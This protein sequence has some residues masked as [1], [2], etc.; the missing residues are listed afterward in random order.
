MYRLKI[1]LIGCNEEVMPP[2]AREILRRWAIIDVD[3]P[4]VTAIQKNVLAKEGETRLLII[5]IRSA[6]DLSDL[7]RLN[8]SYPRYPILAV[9][10][11]TSD[12]TLVVKIMRAG[13]LQVVSPPVLADDLREALEC[14]VAKHEGLSKLAKLITVTGTVGGCGGTTVAINLAY[15][16]ARRAKARSILMELSLRKGVLAN[17]L[18]IY[19]RYTTTDLVTDIRR[20]DSYIL[21]GAL[22]EVA[23]NFCVLAGPYISIQTEKADLDST[24]QLVQLTRHL[25]DSLVL[26]VPSTYDDLFF[27]SLMTADQIVLVADQTV[28]AIRGVQMLCDSLGQRHPIVV[29]NRYDPSSGLSVDK[30]RGFL[31]GCNICTLANDLAVVASMSCGKS[32]RQYSRR[33][34]TLADFDALLRKLEPEAQELG[35]DKKNRSILRRLGHALCLS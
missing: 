30:I 9:V 29:I 11:A 3:Y 17:T 35:R 12:P 22:T 6:N 18:D 27:R 26:D 28:A 7:K 4:S 24:M 23:E 8:S 10:D 1:N 19:P 14:I 15:E 34:S 25:A 13:A 31:P 5:H 2:A 21:Q 20:V 32:L 33:S 16:L